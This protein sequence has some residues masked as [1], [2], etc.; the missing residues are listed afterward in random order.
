MNGRLQG[1]PFS[2]DIAKPDSLGEWGVA[3]GL[4]LSQPTRREGWLETTTERQTKLVEP[5]NSF[6]FV[7][8]AMR[9]P[10]VYLGRNGCSS[11]RHQPGGRG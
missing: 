2:H 11:M 3:E 4:P 6:S 10:K 1:R 5:H 8:R 9:N 7:P